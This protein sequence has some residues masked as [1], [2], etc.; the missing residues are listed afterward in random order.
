[1]QYGI[2]TW[3]LRLKPIA[4]G[5]LLIAGQAWAGAT[6]E[7]NSGM[8][9]YR[10]HDYQQAVIFFE[11]ARKQGLNKVAVYYNLGVSYYRLGKYDQ[12]IPMFERVTRF[13]KMA[14][15]GYYNLGLIAREQK[16]DQLASSHFNKVISTSKNDKLVYLAR[17][18]LEEI[19]APVGIWKGI[20]LVEAGYDDNVSNTAL[21]VA[22][23]GDAYVTLRAHINSLLSGTPGEGWK[24]YLD[25]YNRSYTTINSY[26]IGSIGGSIQRNMRLFGK[27]GYLGG[28]FK[29]LTLG[30]SEYE[31]IGGL[32]VSLENVAESGARYGY[33]YRI[34]SIM[35]AP[36]YNYLEGTRQRVDL[37][38]RSTIRKNAS[39]RLAYRLE[40]NDRRNSATA[41][42]SNVRHDFRSSYYLR[43]DDKTLW[44]FQGRY[45][46][47]D[48]TP[49]AAQNRDD[50]MLQLGVRRSRKIGKDLEWQLQYTMTTNNSTDAT[51]TYTSNVI[52]AGIRKQ[53]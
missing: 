11:K 31:K 5:L 2:L 7:F 27:Q 4:F 50:S 30:G 53:F 12:A 16:N 19:D 8:K 47:S 49:V 39:L 43:T 22:S 42:Y 34:D 40:V 24:T 10:N 18:N 29:V 35:A 13:P 14:D 17:R 37:V 9:A 52:Q 23:K 21:G 33:R 26:S 45:R 25:F 44:R 1:M 36:A 51:Y 3:M 15:A 6:D 46:F 20:A 38:R 48:Y 32:D 28:S 41:S